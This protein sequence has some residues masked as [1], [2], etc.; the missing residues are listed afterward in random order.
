MFPKTITLAG[1]VM[2]AMQYKQSTRQLHFY[3]KCCKIPQ[4][5]GVSRFHA[6]VYQNKFL[7]IIFTICT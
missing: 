7:H 1:E 5:G 6:T 3:L 2:M 4:M